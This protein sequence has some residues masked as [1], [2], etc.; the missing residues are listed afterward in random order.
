MPKDLT[1]RNEVWDSLSEIF[2]EPTTATNRTLRGKVVKS[3]LGADATRD[4]IYSRARAWPLHF[5]DATLTPTALEKW[6]DQLGRP[7]LRGSRS[8]VEKHLRGEEIRR[9]LGTE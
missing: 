9:R 3:L 4:D 1:K 5:P 8:Q 6:W 7:V 2:G